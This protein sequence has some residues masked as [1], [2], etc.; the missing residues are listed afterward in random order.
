MHAL[1]KSALALSV[2]ATLLGHSLLAQ[3]DHRIETVIAVPSIKVSYSDL[4]I[5][6]SSG[7]ELLY[8]RI[9]HAARSVCSFDDQAPMEL[10]KGQAVRTCYRSAV[11]NAVSQI[12]RPMLTALH[13]VKSRQALG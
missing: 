7:L 6:K 3:A 1:V 4:D 8:S 9:Q 11:D 2:G 5:S 13:R 12:N 10:A